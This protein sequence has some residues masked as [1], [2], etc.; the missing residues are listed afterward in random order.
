MAPAGGNLFTYPNNVKA[1][2]I[3]IASEYSG[4][5]VDI[6]Q[7]FVYGETNRTPEFLAKFP[8]GRV[9]AFETKKDVF[10]CESNAIASYICPAE[11]LGGEDQAKRANILEW[12]FLSESQIWSGVCNVVFPKLGLLQTG[13]EDQEKAKLC[14]Y[15]ELKTINEQ[16]RLKTYLVG[17]GLTLAD[18]TLMTSLLL[19]FHHGWGEPDCHERSQF[20]HLF[21]WYQTVVN[22]KK[23]KSVL[24]DLHLGFQAPGRIDG[25]SRSARI[26]PS[27]FPIHILLSF[28][29]RI[30]FS[31]PELLNFK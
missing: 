2:K 17:E 29:C 4:L 8:S 11:W 30:T 12:M 19:L 5:K 13:P 10:L 24:A 27:S 16:L 23:I 1:L 7:D 26:I 28:A 31:S 18:V 25:L 15:Q 6:P 14:L 9:P 21:R 3:L 22:Q 20:P